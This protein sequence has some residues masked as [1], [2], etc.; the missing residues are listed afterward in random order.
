M[1]V[2]LVKRRKIVVVQFR[3]IEACLCIIW[4]WGRLGWLGWWLVTR[5]WWF[6]GVGRG[7]DCWWASGLGGGMEKDVL[8]LF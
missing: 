5:W 1:V 4:G 2:V 8:L 3:Y 7:W 6:A